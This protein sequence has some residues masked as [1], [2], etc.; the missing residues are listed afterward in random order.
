M[1]WASDLENGDDQG[2]VSM[3][4]LY[5]SIMVGGDVRVM[6]AGN[7]LRIAIRGIMQKR[8]DSDWMKAMAA[9]SAVQQS[10]WSGKSPN[11]LVTILVGEAE[12]KRISSG[13]TGLGDAFAFFV[14][15]N[16]PADTIDNT[17]T[18]EFTH[19]WV[20]HRIGGFPGG[21][22]DEA[23]SYWLSEGFTDYVKM[24]MM[25]RTGMWSDKDFFDEFNGLNAR[26]SRSPYRS[27][28]NVE[29]AKKFWNDGDAQQLPYDRGSMLAMLF[30]SEVRRV[31]K[32]KK[33]FDDILLDMHQRASKNSKLDAI[34]QLKRSMKRAGVAI[35]PLLKKHIEQGIPISLP[36]DNF[37]PCGPLTM[38]PLKK[39]E[40]G[41]SMSETV[42]AGIV[43]GLVEGSPA[44][45]AGL[46]N[47]MKAKGW[48]VWSG[49]TQKDA[50]FTVED[51]AG[52]KTYKWKP[53]SDTIVSH[54]VLKLI[55]NMTEED[56]QLCHRRIGGA[57]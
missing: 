12:G 48:A 41:L 22:V 56:A 25:V 57:V 50:E 28:L 40:L 38:Q 2:L 6:N 11:Y 16:A 45:R 32:G 15:A 51:G 39:W 49:D 5:R 34:G 8:T 7:G 53:V 18:H 24:R 9:I 17:L 21:G 13:G 19:S 20:P 37:A 10:F 46:R 1:A 44:W 54:Q 55:D 47:G 30:D 3:H 43:T 33:G 4:A 35:D 26:I 42:K 36:E 52:L 29:V 23:E 31:T 27:S 14:S